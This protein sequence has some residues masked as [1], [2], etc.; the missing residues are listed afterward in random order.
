MKK[1]IF[2][3]A[4][5][6]FLWQCATVPITGR[7]QMK[8]L[9]SSQLQSMS[10][11]QYDQFK[12]ENKVLPDSDPRVKMVKKVGAKISVAV[13]QFLQDNNMKDR[14]KEFN[15]EFN[16]TE[17]NVVNAWC[18][19]GGKVMF[20]TGILPVCDGEEGIA[21]VMGHEIAHAV[22][23]HG[24]ERMSQGLA[25]QA[26]GMALSVA[27]QEKSEMTQNLFLSSYGIGSQL[28]VLKYS[29]LHESE[30][31]KMGLVFM[32][33]AGYEP[34]VA[35]NFWQRM[36]DKK[37]GG[38]P[39]EFLST[40]PSDETRIKDIQNFLPKARTYLKQ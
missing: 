27:M 3:F 37:G 30:A 26:G 14:L 31:D 23:R 15:W 19:P 38:A 8:L 28:G 21:T 12:Q 20:Y 17:Q 33:M 11:T 16:V 1:G 2:I 5:A 10:L 18:M 34:G 22:A 24:N 7:K 36:A 6:F 35:V 40:H 32:A 25:V 29:R 4:T 39:P 9:P 13:N